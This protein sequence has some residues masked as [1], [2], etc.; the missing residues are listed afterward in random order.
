MI[1]DLLSR[2]DKTKQ[3]DHNRWIA[4]CP[5]HDDKNPSL[6]I[7][8][9]NGTTLLKCFAG[10]SAYEIVSAVGLELSDLFPERRDGYSKPIKNPF[11]ASDVLRCIKTEALIVVIAACN[12]ANGKPLK[13]EDKTRLLLAA[14]RIQGAYNE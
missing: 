8:E 4:L 7:R 14:G 6:A 2:L 11:P 3:T 13:D 9:V 5:S 1:A 12:M 10:C